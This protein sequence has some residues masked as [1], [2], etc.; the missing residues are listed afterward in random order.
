MNAGADEHCDIPIFV[1]PHLILKYDAEYFVCAVWVLWR[2][3]RIHA[4]SSSCRSSRLRAGTPTHIPSPSSAVSPMAG[5]SCAAAK[6]NVKRA[7]AQITSCVTPAIFP[8]PSPR[9]RPK[10]KSRRRFA[11]GEGLRRNPEAQIRI[12]HQWPGN[13]RIRLHHRHRAV[14]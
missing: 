14:R 2:P 9:P 5:S 4:G 12:R 6:L 7:N 8:L 11:A 3:K 1:S 10:Q 13:H